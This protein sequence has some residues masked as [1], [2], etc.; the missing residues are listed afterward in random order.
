[1][2]RLWDFRLLEVTPLM[3]ELLFIHLTYLTWSGE[4]PHRTA[5]SHPEQRRISRLVLLLGRQSKRLS[6]VGHLSGYVTIMKCKDDSPMPD[7][8]CAVAVRLEDL[9]TLHYVFFMGLR[10]RKFD[11]SIFKK[12]LDLPQVRFHHS[13]RPALDIKMQHAGPKCFSLEQGAFWHFALQLLKPHPVAS[14]VLQKDF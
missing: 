10:G 11:P 5:H 12:Q 6:I 14:S 9:F 7:S 4:W 3:L 2:E 8:P 13:C 1:M